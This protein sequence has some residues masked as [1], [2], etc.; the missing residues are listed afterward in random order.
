M[1]SDSRQNGDTRITLRPLSFDDALRAL[2]N[3]PKRE[4]SQP[5]ESCST[6]EAAPESET[7][8][9][10]GAGGL[11]RVNVGIKGKPEFLSRVGLS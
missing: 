11:F 2:I 6:T 4:D 8:E 10:P 5:D 9:G 7:E 3:V 1:T